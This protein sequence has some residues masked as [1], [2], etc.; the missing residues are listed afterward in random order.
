MIPID[1][2]WTFISFIRN[3]FSSSLPHIITVLDHIGGDFT[4]GDGTG[5]ESIYGETFPDENFKIKHSAPGYISM[6][7]A[8]MLKCVRY[9]TEINYHHGCISFL[10][11]FLKIRPGYS[12]ESIF[13]H[14]RHYKLA[15]WKTRCIW[16]GVGGY[17]CCQSYR[18]SWLS[19][20]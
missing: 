8:G 15:W 13:H 18:S 3:A 11:T 6:A 7:N 12:G 10:F 5:G 17:G 14:H 2:W 20:W 9:S 1:T 16:K 19:V 4:K